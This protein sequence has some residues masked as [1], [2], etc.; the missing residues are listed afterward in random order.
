LIIGVLL[1]GFGG[2]HIDRSRGRVRPSACNDQIKQLA[3]DA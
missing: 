2:E 1:V 3:K